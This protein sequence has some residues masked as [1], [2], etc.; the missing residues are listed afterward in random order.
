MPVL[1]LLDNFQ[2]L[3]SAT[4]NKKKPGSNYF[5]TNCKVSGHSIDRCFKIHGFPPGF[6]QNRYKKVAAVSQSTSEGAVT[7][8]ADIINS[9]AS[10][11]SISVEQYNHLVELPNNQKIQ[12]SN[13]N[14]ASES[15]AALA[16]KTCLLTASFNSIWLL[17]SGA[18]D[19]ICPTLDDFSEFKDITSSDNKITIPDG[20]QVIA[21]HT[22]HIQ[23]NDTPQLRDVLHVP[24]FQF[25]LL[26]VHKLCKDLNCQLLFSDDI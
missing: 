16:G 17:D 13:V 18:T 20:K 4:F 7:D 1:M 22:G 3:I 11:N 8:S 19:H 21:L 15:H 26:S 23:L 5:C 9:N 25:K 10:V 6:K 12:S 2:R 14:A 24:D